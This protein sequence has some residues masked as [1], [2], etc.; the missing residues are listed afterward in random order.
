MIGANGIDRIHCAPDRTYAS[1]VACA[2]RY[3]D[4]FTTRI[5]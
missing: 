4:E 1:G 3:Y 2:A 5:G